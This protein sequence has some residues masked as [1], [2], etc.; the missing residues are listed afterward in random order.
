MTWIIHTSSVAEWGAVES[1]NYSNCSSITIQ[2]YYSCIVYFLFSTLVNCSLVRALF[3]LSLIIMSIVRTHSLLL[4]L[5]FENGGDVLRSHLMRMFNF[6]ESINASWAWSTRSCT[7]LGLEKYSY[8]VKQARYA[9]SRYASW[10][11]L[12]I[13]TRA[14]GPRYGRKLPLTIE[15]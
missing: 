15:I 2:C 8:I 10:Y 13:R 9:C 11:S 12:Y 7:S 6:I 14:F 5:S 3:S 4:F 1:V